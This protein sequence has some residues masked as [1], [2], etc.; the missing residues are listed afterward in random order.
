MVTRAIVTI[1][2]VVIVAGGGY[3]ASRALSPA[4]A[5]ATLSA[6]HTVPIELERPQVI[7]SGGSSPGR[8][9]PLAAP[10]P[11]RRG[12]RAPEP[13]RPP[14][15]PASP[16]RPK[17]PETAPAPPSKSLPPAPAPPSSPPVPPVP[18]QAPGT[19]DGHDDGGN[20]SSGN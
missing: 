16:G 19:D 14:T 10:D 12:P 17:Q 4:G 1:A 9:P 20:W 15:A 3:G 18:P 13:E 8:L 2:V 11:R 7:I 5:P 6:R